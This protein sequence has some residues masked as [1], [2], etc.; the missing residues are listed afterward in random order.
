MASN[1]AQSLSLNQLLKDT[2]IIEC[3][4]WFEVGLEL[5]LAY[6]QLDIIRRDHPNDTAA[7]KREMWNLWLNNGRLLDLEEVYQKIRCVE[8]RVRKQNRK[9][10][11]D[12]DKRAEDAIQQ[13]EESFKRFKQYNEIIARN[14]RSLVNEL[15]HEKDWLSGTKESEEE[16]EVE[17]RQGGKATT[18][19]NLK[20]AIE[21]GNF[22]RSRFVRQFF[23][24]KS[25]SL[26]SMGTLD[27]E[28]HLYR[29][30][31]RIKLERSKTV[32]D[33][34]RKRK[35]HDGRVK[36]LLKEI[37]DSEN[38][39]RKRLRT[40]DQITEGL[41]RLGIDQS[42]LDKLDEEVGNV[43]T[44]LQECTQARKDCAKVY[45][46]G[47]QNLQQSQVQVKELLES[48]ENFTTKVRSREEQLRSREEE[49]KSLFE[50][51]KEGA[52][53][54]A[55]IGARLHFIFGIIPGGIIGGI[56]GL[57]KGLFHDK[58]RL[59]RELQENLDNS[60]RMI[61]NCKEIL[62]RAEQESDELKNTLKED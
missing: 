13:L 47:R 1:Q 12:D 31:E 15:T 32:R 24:Q 40:Y 52:I 60:R 51:I 22:Q 33:R 14:H 43:K 8:R 45:E 6:Y 54:G 41:K 20:E 19:D 50:N 28:Y 38:L 39:I 29:E 3:N 57:I 53:Y 16:E 62:T 37:E 9:E 42:K 17:W 34:H 11:E 27:I 7:C 25:M 26:D 23:Q 49:I 36:D 56:A 58:E 59:T 18:L 30:L 21:T 48:F 55:G 44:T 4:E 46:N 2:T 61:Q 35:D 10:I 5:G